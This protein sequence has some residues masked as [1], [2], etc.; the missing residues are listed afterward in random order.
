MPDQLRSKK[1]ADI[2]TRLSE[3]GVREEDLCEKFI[4]ASGP[5]GQNV[6]KVATCVELFHKPSGIRV[7]ESSFRSQAANRLRAREV[8]IEK[9]K[10]RKAACRRA[11]SAE[12]FK[13]NARKRKRLRKVQ[14][15]VLENKRQRSQRKQS[16]KRISRSSLDP[17]L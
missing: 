13:E 1:G 3:V 4:L 17:F 6:N 14:E 16:R 5:G 15:A 2:S 11:A 8:L 9:L 7:K 10:A 12:R